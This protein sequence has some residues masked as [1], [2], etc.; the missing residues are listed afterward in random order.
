MKTALRYI[1]YLIMI[2]LL[3]CGCSEKSFENKNLTFKGASDFDLCVD[4]TKTLTVQLPDNGVEATLSASV[5]GNGLSVEIIDNSK[6]ILTGSAVGEYNITFTLSAKGY[7][8]AD[9]VFPAYVY[10]KELP[11]T[12]LIDGA[13]FSDGFSIDHRETVEVELKHDLTDTELSLSTPDSEMLDIMQDGTKY[14]I[15]AKAAGV[16]TVHIKSPL[17]EYRDFIFPIEIEKIKVDFS[18]TADRRTAIVGENVIFDCH[19]PPDSN[20]YITGIPDDASAVKDGNKIIFTSSK[21]GAYHITVWCEGESYIRAPQNMFAEFVLPPL[22]FSA[23]ASITLESGDS[24]SFALSGY[25]E[26]TTFSV[27]SGGKASVSISGGN[28]SVTARAAGNDTLTVTAHNPNY[29]SSSAK[30]P[31]TIN[32]V[33][34]KVSSKYEKQINEII[35]LVNKE[36]TDRGYSALTYLPELAAACTIRAE[37]CSD[38]WSHTRPNGSN[39]E[40][41]LYDTGVNFISGGENLLEM[42]ALSPTEAVA[43]WMASPGHKANILRPN[44][45]ATCVAIYKDGENYYYAQHFI[46]R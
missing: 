4:E 36:R 38:K 12:V 42:N 19:Y 1:L 17:P 46:E 2:S 3:L 27:S 23:P 39:W 16:A 9:A 6:I 26:G 35:R 29:Q 25:P 20:I 41:A 14:I 30:I 5:D 18:Y 34:V 24:T 28:V 40:T 32:A 31:V 10:P 44:V 11:V 37:E 8:S 22:N 15:T 43:A 7:I 21:P 45:N 33:S 13:E